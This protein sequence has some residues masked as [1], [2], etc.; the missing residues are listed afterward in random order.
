MTALT[1]TDTFDKYEELAAKSD[2][3][4]GKD[5]AL[6]WLGL[7]GEIGGLLTIAKKY[8]RDSA[9][10]KQLAD[11]MLEELGDVFWYL[12]AICRRK[13]WHLGE[14][15]NRVGKSRIKGFVKEASPPIT[16][17]DKIGQP[18]LKTNKPEYL[19]KLKELSIAASEAMHPRRILLETCQNKIQAVFGI[20][21][22]VSHACDI[23][24]SH[25]L[26]ENIGKIFSRW[27]P[28]NS[29]AH[30]PVFENKKVPLFEQLPKEITIDIWEIDG[31]NPPIAMQQINGINIGDRLTDNISVGDF[32][33]FHDVFH[34]AYAAILHW[35]PVTRALLRTKRKYDSVLDMNQ[36]GARAIL[37][38]E[39]VATFVFN[40]AKRNNNFQGISEGELSYDLLKMISSLVE[41]YEV[42]KCPLWLWERAILEG[43]KVFQYL[44]DNKKGRIMIDAT[45]RTIIVGPLP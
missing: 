24:L 39:G 41:G 12:S 22:D 20:L 44:Q 43:F 36:D 11:A 34:Y 37:I 1:L 21:L 5:E 30:L 3:L 15:A 13:G 32:Y 29:F 17:L 14:F 7:S 38:E 9:P 31:S 45:Q 40:V 27:P 42:E 25:A 35:S 28:D 6:V 16:M 26:Q 8:K 10:P 4:V 19:E 23:K 18:R 33:R 2:K